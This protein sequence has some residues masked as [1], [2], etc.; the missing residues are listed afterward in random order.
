MECSNHVNTSD[1]GEKV[2]ESRHGTWPA[3]HLRP[4]DG[5]CGQ[6]GDSD[7]ERRFAP[8]SMRE[9]I[10]DSGKRDNSVLF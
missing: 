10:G 6:S 5:N 4:G 9:G 2:A 7:Q 8:S 3:D 1:R